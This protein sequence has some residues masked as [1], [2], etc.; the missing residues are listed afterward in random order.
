MKRCLAGRLLSITLLLIV[1]MIFSTFQPCLA[2][3]HMIFRKYFWNYH[4]KGYLLGIKIPLDD[5]L[6]Y[7]S[8]PLDERVGNASEDYSRLVTYSD[9]VVVDVALRLKKLAEEDKLNRLQTAEFVL[10]FVQGHYLS[11]NFTENVGE[12]PKFPVETLVEGGG[13]CED[14]AILAAAILK[15]MG[16]DV[17]LIDIESNPR[18]MA[19]GIALN[20]SG[21]GIEYNGVKYLYAETTSMGWPVGVIPQKFKNITMKPIP[22]NNDIIKPKKMELDQVRYMLD[23]LN[24]TLTSYNMIYEQFM[25]VAESNQ[26]L[27]KMY[28]TLYIVYSSLEREHYNL[29]QGVKEMKEKLLQFVMFSSIGFAAIG[30]I[31]AYIAYRMGFK[32]GIRKAEEAS[33]ESR[34]T[35]E[36]PAELPGEN[37]SE[38]QNLAENQAEK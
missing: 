3:K 12:F 19:I 18:H 34:Q 1:T 6:G 14:S 9:P 36:E 32:R 13:D 35:P 4:E 2:E 26:R 10:S 37:V 5:Y 27:W 8:I 20:S 31:G 15:A 21:E 16:Y 33:A 24:Q 38:K 7:A 28:S 17:I 30:S 11:E 22:I 29:K 23:I 25:K